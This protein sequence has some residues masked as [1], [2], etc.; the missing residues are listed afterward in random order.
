MQFLVNVI[1]NS[2]ELA[3]VEEM[4]AIDT[5]NEHLMAEGRWVFAAGLSAP[6]TAKVVDNRAGIGSVVSGP[7][8]EGAEFVAGFWIWDAPD[9]STALALAVDGS[10]ACNRKLEVRQLLG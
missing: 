6:H 5:F 7:A 2:S 3:T 1:H 4:E 9:P 8:F 10:K